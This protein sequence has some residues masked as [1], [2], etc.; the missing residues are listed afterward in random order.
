MPLAMPNFIELDQMMYKKSVRKNLTLFN[1]FE[2]K[3]CLRKSRPKF[4]QFWEQLSIGKTRVL[5]ILL[6]KFAKIGK[7]LLR[8]NAPHHAKFH[9]AWPQDVRTKCNILHPSVF[10]GLMGIPWAKVHQYWPWCTAKPY[11]IN[12]LNYVDF[13]EDV[14]NKKHTMWKNM[15]V[16]CHLLNPS[17]VQHFSKCFLTVLLRLNSRLHKP[18]INCL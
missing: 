17:K 10:W 4:T 16:Q 6:W 1:I 7:D 13:A 5:P 14:S 15:Q 9:R 3:F 18:Q 12:L 8:T 11:L 2:K